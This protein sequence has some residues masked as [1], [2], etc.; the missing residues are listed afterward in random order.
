MLCVWF[1]EPL[2][3]SGFHY[4]LLHAALPFGYSGPCHQVW[5][6]LPKSHANQNKMP[7]HPT[8]I[9]LDGGQKLHYFQGWQVVE[10]HPG[11]EFIRLSR[12][13]G[14]V[15]E[16]EDV[17]K[18]VRAPNRKSD[19][20]QLRGILS[21]STVR[22]SDARVA[23]DAHLIMVIH[24][25]LSRI[26][27]L[28]NNNATSGRGR[29][30]QSLVSFSRFDTAKTHCKYHDCMNVWHLKHLKFKS[31]CNKKS[32][33]TQN[34]DPVLH[35]HMLHTKLNTICR[36]S[37]NHHQKDTEKHETWLE[38]IIALKTFA[39]PAQVYH[40][41][42]WTAQN[43]KTSKILFELSEASPQIL[44]FLRIFS[45]VQGFETSPWMG[46]DPQSQVFS[47]HFSK[48]RFAGLLLSESEEDGWMGIHPWHFWFRPKKIY[49]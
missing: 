24:V 2:S 1:A 11:G 35:F 37:D 32:S 22:S 13:Q 3:F 8:P 12:L 9:F 34:Q 16:A 17:T 41:Q 48:T 29:V 44:G 14:P 26:M 10:S 28:H 46:W 7:P 39:A 19:P 47:A 21:T 36:N 31:C 27:A 43:L 4:R 49:A 18:D 42:G 33:E 5:I 38:R 20:G 40:S 25:E 15:E 45:A 6:W 30:T 23:S